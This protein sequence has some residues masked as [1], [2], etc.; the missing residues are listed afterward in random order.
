MDPNPTPAPRYTI[1]L[2]VN[3][4]VEGSPA[5]IRGVTQNLSSTGVLIQASKQVARG[6]AVR[7]DFKDFK[8]NGEIIWS[9]R[10]EEEILLGVRFVSL[11]W[12]A[13]RTLNGILAK[14]GGGDA[15]DS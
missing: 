6:S 3:L 14:H 12:G 15:T 13:R 1:R 2:V 9:H 4:T 10:R 8:A 11:G 5:S 7:M